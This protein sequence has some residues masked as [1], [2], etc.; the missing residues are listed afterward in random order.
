MDQSNTTY[1]SILDRTYSATGGILGRS[2]HCA[3]IM[4]MVLWTSPTPHLVVFW[5][6]PILRLVEFWAGPDPA[7]VRQIFSPDR[8]QSYNLTPGWNANRGRDSFIQSCVLVFLPYFKCML[9]P[10][11]TIIFVIKTAIFHGQPTFCLSICYLKISQNCK[12]SLPLKFA[13]QYEDCTF[14]Y[15]IHNWWCTSCFLDPSTVIV[16]E[17]GRGEG[18]EGVWEEGR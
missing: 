4:C 3:P 9:L 8:F 15:F 17:K 11:L 7:T 16:R 13:V 1:G 10:L 2:R 6:G 14:D 12:V 18:R 5:T